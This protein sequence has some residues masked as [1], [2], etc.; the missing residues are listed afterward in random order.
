MQPPS[1]RRQQE[2][3][4]LLG[5]GNESYS[6]LLS[7]EK[8]AFAVTSPRPLPEVTMASGRECAGE[9]C[10]HHGRP[11]TPGRILSM[12]GTVC[13]VLSSVTAHGSSVISFPHR[14]IRPYDTADR[15]HRS[16][17]KKSAPTLTGYLTVRYRSSVSPV[18]IGAGCPAE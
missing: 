16:L 6:R 14:Q 4:G 18:T 8:T 9:R 10:G 17:S 13:Q 3:Q 15:P 1:G 5:Q 2:L 11:D 12:L 7:G